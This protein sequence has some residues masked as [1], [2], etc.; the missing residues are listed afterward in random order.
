MQVEVELL[1]GHHVPEESMLLLRYPRHDPTAV[2]VAGV[3][4]GCADGGRQEQPSGEPKHL[5]IFLSG[6]SVRSRERN[7]KNALSNRQTR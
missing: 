7:V 6:I 4:I 3:A 5:E 1:L 2:S